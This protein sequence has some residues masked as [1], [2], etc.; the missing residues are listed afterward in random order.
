LDVVAS[1]LPENC[2]ISPSLDVAAPGLPENRDIS[3]SL[4][5]IDLDSKEEV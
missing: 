3:P 5:A 2:D 4:D 1:G